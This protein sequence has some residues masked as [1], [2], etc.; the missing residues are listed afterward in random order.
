MNYYVLVH[1]KRNDE[2]YSSG[3]YNYQKAVIT[4]N[5]IVNNELKKSKKFNY[6]ELNKEVF[7]V[8]EG[9]KVIIKRKL[10]ALGYFYNTSSVIDDVI[11]WIV[12]SYE[13]NDSL[14]KD[15]VNIYSQVLDELN[16]K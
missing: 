13:D 9:D 4:K 16:K 6:G 2:F 10:Y 12:K 7:C 3:P 5:I 1:A 15:P 8:F 11:V 14:L